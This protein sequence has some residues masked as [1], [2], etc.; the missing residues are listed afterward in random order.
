MVHVYAALHMEY[1]SQGTLPTF[2]VNA[3]SCRVAKA[4]CSCAGSDNQAVCTDDGARLSLLTVYTEA[5][6][7]SG[8][9]A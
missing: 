8:N 6:E 9:R 1:Q 2:Y 4:V 3:A 5:S 7:R